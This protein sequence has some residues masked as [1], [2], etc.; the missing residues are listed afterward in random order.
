[1]SSASTGLAPSPGT[2]RGRGGRRA[3]AAK[4]AGVATVVVAL[5][6]AV[7]AL[8]FNAVVLDHLNATV[9]VRLADQLDD[10]SRPAPDVGL[11]P[12]FGASDRD[13]DAAPVFTWHV[14][15]TGTAQAVTVGAPALPRRTWGSGPVELTVAGSTFRFV[16][17]STASGWVVA[18]SSVHQVQRVGAE[19]TVAELLLGGVLV[20]STFVGALVVGLRASA[21]V[22]AMRRSQAEFTAD[23]SHELRT[24]L[25]V[26]RAEVDLALGR[27]RS[28]DSYR[29]TLERVADEG[30]RLQSIVDDLLWLAREEAAPPE[31]SR[32]H[33]RVDLA[34]VATSTAQRFA[35]VADA[36]G[37][38]LVV[39]HG[40]PG[41][42]VVHATPESLQ[43]LA[44]V[45][46]DNACRYTGPGGTIR[47]ATGAAGGR[48]T[49][50]VEDSGPGIP[51]DERHRIFDRFHRASDEPGG[52]GLGLAIADAV[53]RRTRGSWSIGSSDLGGAR[54]TVAWRRPPLHPAGLRAAQPPERPRGDD[55]DGVEPDASSAPSSGNARPG[56]I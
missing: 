37:Q 18:G 42:A 30:R 36:A 20:V 28:A 17:R 29:A 11:V 14:D 40:Q 51:E 10:A 22:E 16:S 12:P 49:L 34:V 56:V 32:T 50:S 4:V 39:E 21:P 53:V 24:P 13:V 47:V 9:D 54:V 33:E 27:P 15:R 52:T 55:G 7:V 35:A 48:A 23:A 31:R 19:L 2:A 45:L 8:V 26:I 3:H 6:V 46:V 44:G 43:R 25:S 41:H 1:M 5:V 38:H